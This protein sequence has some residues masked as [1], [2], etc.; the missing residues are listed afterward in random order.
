M[1]TLY[2]IHVSRLCS[3]YFEEIR[4]QE[5]YWS[6]ILTNDINEI[7]NVTDQMDDRMRSNKSRGYDYQAVIAIVKTNN[8][9]NDHVIIQQLYQGHTNVL[10]KD[11][12][13]DKPYTQIR[14]REI[15]FGSCY[16]DD[17]EKDNGDN[18]SDDDD[19]VIIVCEI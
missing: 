10:L 14:K 17:T 19:D 12:Q 9:C 18:N 11:L 3:D 2:H 4:W 6:L 13:F 16:R 1:T 15:Y 7:I 5:G 8:K